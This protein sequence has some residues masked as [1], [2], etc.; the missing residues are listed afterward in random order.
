MLVQGLT[1]ISCH[2][3]IGSVN[4]K[5]KNRINKITETYDSIFFQPCSKKAIHDAFKKTEAQ[6]KE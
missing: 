3:W 6:S 1:L 4:S 2:A 5:M